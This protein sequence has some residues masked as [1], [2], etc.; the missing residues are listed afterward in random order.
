MISVIILTLN[1]EVNLPACLESVRWSNDIVVFDSYSTDRTVEI[2]RAFGARVIQRH[3]DNELNQRAA[4]LQVDFKH[5]WVFIPDADEV[6]E[7][8]L[9]EEMRTVVG[10]PNRREVA[11]RMRFKTIFMGQW[12]KHSS[13]YPTWIMR[14]VQP[15]HIRPERAINT[16]Y[17]TEGLEG[18]LQNHLEHYTFRNGLDAW[19]AKHNRYAK[20]EAS[21]NITDLSCASLRDFADVINITNPVLRR[22]AM[23]LLSMCLPFRPSLRFLFMYCLRGGFLDGR[24]GL[25]YCR[26]MAWYEFM[27][28]L[29]LREL[30]RRA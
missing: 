6:A 28:V 11:Y 30:R 25:T 26:L 10:D 4:S 18:R 5:P 13:L 24:A 2:A 27:I 7:P 9:C 8:L 20:V 29:N 22:R 23:K 21:Q 16:G 14:L 17:R 19:V 1:E 3:Y 15:A 12:I